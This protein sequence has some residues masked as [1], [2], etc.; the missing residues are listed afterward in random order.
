MR[1]I[2]SLLFTTAVVL[3]S[4]SLCAQDPV[5]ITKEEIQLENAL[6]DAEL[7]LV[8]E[9][10]EDAE[11]AYSKVLQQADDN[12]AAHFGRARALTEMD[13][14]DDALKSFEQA[15]TYDPDN[16]WYYLAL[17]Q[18]QESL[19][20][21]QAAARTYKR[22]VE[23]APDRPQ[24]MIDLAYAQLRSGDLRTGTATLETYEDTYGPQPQSTSRLMDL[25][26][27]TDDEKKAIRVA[28]RY[29][30]LKPNDTSI[31]MQLAEY[32]HAQGRKTE[33]AELYERILRVD[34]DHTAASLALA[35]ISSGKSSS[36]DPLQELYAILE[37][38]SMELDPKVKQLI[39][40]VEEFVSGNPRDSQG[41]SES[42]NA[43]D[44]GP[45]LARATEILLKAHPYDAKSYAIA[46]DVQTQLGDFPSAIENYEKSLELKS[47]NYQ[48]WEQLLYLYRDQ[49][50]YD[51]MHDL[52]QEALDYFPT[53]A[54][55]FLLA[56]YAAYHYERDVSLALDLLEEQ[57]IMTSRR[58]VERYHG[59]LLAARAYAYEG[60]LA[61]AKQKIE[62]AQSIESDAAASHIEMAA[63]QLAGTQPADALKTLTAHQAID[64]S[65][66]HEIRGLALY[67]LSDPAASGAMQ[68]AI[69][70]QADPAIWISW[71]D[72]LY[73]AGDKAGAVEKWEQAQA[74]LPYESSIVQD[75]ITSASK[76]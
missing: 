1:T 45:S 63:L 71:G 43:R 60:D 62:Q 41:S 75:K 23:K 11:L 4:L 49:Y 15:L 56:A 29:L 70:L 74:A 44:L 38:P 25:Y 34:P 59:C 31:A 10:Y 8:L 72:A 55:I 48:V 22:L 64:M 14:K 18:Y 13:R 50:Q 28:Q 12:A 76:S 36:D 65:R 19:Q 52:A 6:I 58:P 73:A 27:H 37:N 42:K 53:K 20:E 17:A 26:L 3:T 61:S 47:T 21:D 57:Y 7:Q 33:A 69:D 9:E 54:E 16:E 35:S 5:R 68:Q 39:P 51:R 40:Y 66:Y 30:D 46:A 2:S 32:Q 67:Q 24:Y